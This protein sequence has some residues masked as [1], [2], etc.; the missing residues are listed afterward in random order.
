MRSDQILGEWIVEALQNHDGTATLVD[1]C[2]FVWEHHRKDL[3]GSGATLLYLALRQSGG[4]QL[5]LGPLTLCDRPLNRH[6]VF[7]SSSGD[8]RPLAHCSASVVALVG[9]RR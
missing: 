2:R 3:I 6:E 5:S 8:G 4:R 7:G 9:S 1:V